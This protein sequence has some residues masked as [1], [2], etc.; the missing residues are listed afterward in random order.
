[1]ASSKLLLPSSAALFQSSP[2]S[3]SPLLYDRY[4]YGSFP[5]PPLRP[6]VLQT[7][8]AESVTV[9]KAFNYEEEGM[10]SDSE[11]SLKDEDMDSEYEEME[12]GPEDEQEEGGLGE[13][14]EEVLRPK[15]F[16]TSS[17]GARSMR[18][19]NPSL[20]RS[21]WSKTRNPTLSR[22]E[23]SAIVDSLV[24]SRSNILTELDKVRYKLAPSDFGN[25][26]QRFIQEKK[27]DRVGLVFDWMKVNKK[28]R[29]QSLS[30]Y[31]TLMGKAGLY[32]RAFRA[33]RGLGDPELKLNKYVC[34]ALL[35]ALVNANSV[36]KAFA[37][38][39]ELKSEGFE[40]D[41]YT[42]STVIAGCAK[43]SD[44]Y[45][46]A[47][48]FFDEMLSRDLKPDAFIYSS[49]LN[50]CA[51]CGLEDEAK[52]I[53]EEMREY[54]VEPA[55]YHYAPL[56]NMYAENKKPREAEKVFKEFSEA[57]LP[58]NQVM[59][60][61]LI[62]AYLNCG[63]L[64]K[65]AK[66]FEDMP[67]LCGAVGDVTYTLMIDSY[68]KA[69][70]VEK[71]QT[72]FEQ[73]KSRGLS[74]GNYVY[75]ILITTYAK[76]GNADMV[77]SLSKELESREQG[78]GDPVLFNSVLKSFCELGMMDAVMN[79]LKRM[80]KESVSPD[81]A[82]FNILICFF[83]KQGMMDV[84][85]QTLD[86]LKA[87]KLRPN[88]N[89][90]MPLITE[91]LKSEKPDEA[92]KLLTQAIENGV[93]PS[94]DLWSSIIDALCQN[95]KLDEVFTQFKTMTEMGIFPLPTCFQNILTIAGSDINI[96][97]QLL[98]YKHIPS[99][100]FDE[101]NLISVLSAYEKQ[102]LY[103][104]M[105]K[106]LD[107]AENENLSVGDGVGLDEM[108]SNLKEGGQTEILAKI[109][110]LSSKGQLAAVSSPS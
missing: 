16:S 85:F 6:L 94:R 23:R 41:A 78:V 84:A 102:G 64:E 21:F 35:K 52:A 42:Y 92:L 1:M 67:S 29:P 37:L 55:T 107:Y 79:T 48:E 14:G 45:A 44:G 83:C 87:R 51:R 97:E 72:L 104:A 19:S 17:A 101:V 93:R 110:G 61:S 66:L 81:R 69:G 108:I 103:T 60:N 46:K 96:L 25:L 10:S 71:A 76:Q 80:N 7:Q 20:K 70:L 47:K 22:E 31:M 65:A 59:V 12:G 27:W 90:Y 36:E 43:R 18:T 95:K 58:M 74:P 68:C 13:E 40:P 49:L 77:S 106:L 99:E 34:N 38:F 88:M 100:V 89:S 33:Y 28:L 57:G 30:V 5:I 53:F 75:S 8:M 63:E 4:R 56:V 9:A 86:D 91:F 32:F 105:H 98:G 24:S 73:I 62:K 11:L 39:E 82:T 109:P 50:V 15:S 2:V 3:S 54:G 26:L